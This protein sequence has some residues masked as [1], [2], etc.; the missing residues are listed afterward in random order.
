VIP[1]VH[2]TQPF[3]DDVVEA[4]DG[5]RPAALVVCGRRAGALARGFRVRGKRGERAQPRLV[6]GPDQPVQR[7]LLA[8]RLA[9]VDEPWIAR[10]RALLIRE[11]DAGPCRT[12]GATAWMSAV[13]WAQPRCRPKRSLTWRVNPRAMERPTSCCSGGR[14]SGQIVYGCDAISLRTSVTTRSG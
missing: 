14:A 6:A 5:S 13:K 1:L 12:A 10:R 9:R 8:P 3:V 2:I 4:G 7:P 11:R